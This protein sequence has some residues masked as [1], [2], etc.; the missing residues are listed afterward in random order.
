MKP[1]WTSRAGPPSACNGNHCP[2][3]AATP[4]L[5]NYLSTNYHFGYTPRSA[6]YSL[7]GS[8]ADTSQTS[9]D[10]G[11]SHLLQRQHHRQIQWNATYRPISRL[12]LSYKSRPQFL[13][14]AGH[15]RPLLSS[16]DQF[17]AR[18]TISSKMEFNYD[19]ARTNS[20]GQVSSGYYNSYNGTTATDTSSAYT[21]DS[22]RFGLTWRPSQKLNFDSSLTKRD[23]NSGG[24]VG[25]LADSSQTTRALTQPSSSTPPCL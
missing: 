2:V 1:A 19:H 25:Y 23:Y 3:S 9:L 17:S 6:V 13:R 18:W 10:S 12:S 16:L 22:S 4:A 24:S 11:G 5:G 8:L 15:H 14:L 21:D 20:L 7:T